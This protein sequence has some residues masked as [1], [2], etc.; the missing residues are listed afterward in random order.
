MDPSGNRQPVATMGA[1]EKGLVHVEK[2]RCAG[3]RYAWYGRARGRQ[4]VGG[5]F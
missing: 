1:C 2:L 4:L 5:A 3:S